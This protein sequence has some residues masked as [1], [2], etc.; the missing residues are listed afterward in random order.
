MARRLKRGAANER[1]RLD[2]DG[3]DDKCQRQCQ[4]IINGGVRSHASQE[5][6]ASKHARGKRRGSHEIRAL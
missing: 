5:R 2:I 1:G 3:F 6:V 4:L